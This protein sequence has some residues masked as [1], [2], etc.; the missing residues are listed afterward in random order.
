MYMIDLETERPLRPIEG[1]SSFINNLHFQD[2]WDHI[3][4]HLTNTFTI[5]FLFK[6]IYLTDNERNYDNLNFCIFVAPW[7]RLVSQEHSWII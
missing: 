7:T 6:I 2:I 4:I 1:S 5:N 3:Q